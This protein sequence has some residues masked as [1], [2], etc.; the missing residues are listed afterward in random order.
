MSILSVDTIQP[1]GSGTSV[2]VNSSATLVL[3][4]ANSTG[5]VTATSFVGSGANLTGLPGGSTG[6]D[7]NDNVKIRLGTGNDLSIFHD[8][9]NAYFTNISG[10]I[11]IQ[12]KSG[13]NSIRAIPDG[14][15]ELYHNNSKKL[16]TTSSGITLSDQL[17]V[18]GTVFATGGLKIN[19]DNQTLRIGAGDDLQLSHDGSDSFIKD[20]GTGALKVCSNLFRVNNA[21][22]TEAMIKAEENAGVTLSYDASTKFETTNTGATITGNLAFP[23]GNGIDFSASGGPQGSGGTELLN[24]YEAGTFTPVLQG[25]N[26]SGTA[27]HTH[28]SGNYVKIGRNCTIFFNIYTTNTASWSGNLRIAGLPFTPG[29]SVEAVGAAQWNRLPDGGSGSSTQSV[30]AVLQNPNTFVEFRKNQSG[31][32]QFSYLSVQNVNYLRVSM[33]YITA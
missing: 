22:N 13:E 1:I 26:G 5:V 16:E 9:S 28:Q 24:D 19:A 32:A 6:L 17:Q 29:S 4:N 14:A 23:S 11:H 31:T 15:V 12:G 10:T 25:S 21:A 20:T 2:T 7:V 27:T 30:F 33:S 3:T 18:T 8:G